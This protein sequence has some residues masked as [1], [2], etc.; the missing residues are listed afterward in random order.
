MPT[1]W[2]FLV[3]QALNSDKTVRLISLLNLYVKYVIDIK[4]LIMDFFKWCHIVH[5]SVP[6]YILIS[7]LMPLQC[8]NP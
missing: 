5:Q 7:I 2:M 1:W 8:K 3:L 6:S 4:F